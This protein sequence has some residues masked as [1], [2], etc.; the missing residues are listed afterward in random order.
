M[1]TAL[2]LEMGL[3]LVLIPWSAFWDRNYFADALPA[4]KTII[5][6]NYVRGAV[7]GLGLVNVWAA[8]SELADIFYGR[9]R[10]DAGL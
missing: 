1:I 5:T 3:L 6:N 2:L 4:L 10:D 9:T 7:M 8:L